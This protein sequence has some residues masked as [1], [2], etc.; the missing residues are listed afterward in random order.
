MLKV[1]WNTVNNL[2]ISGSEDKKFKVWD[3]YGRQLY[4]STAQ[5]YPITS[6]SWNPSGDLFAVGSH[7][8]IRICDKLGVRRWLIDSGLKLL[9]NVQMLDLFLILLGLQTVLK[10][11]EQEVRL[12]FI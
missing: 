8:M 9:K 1:D 2:I 6:L 10:L 5:E 3:A 11:L 4:S 7:N 12:I